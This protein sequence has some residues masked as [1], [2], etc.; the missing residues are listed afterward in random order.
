MLENLLD[1]VDAHCPRPQPLR[2]TLDAALAA[3]DRGQNKAAITQIEAFE[4]K[5]EA[6][7]APS[8]PGLSRLLLVEAQNITAALGAQEGPRN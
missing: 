3:L 5:V 7:V 4:Q 2:A 6:Q 8:N 1:L